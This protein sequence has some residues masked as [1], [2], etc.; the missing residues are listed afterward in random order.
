MQ[1]GDSPDSKS[2][3]AEKL[4]IIEASITDPNILKEVLDATAQQISSDQTSTSTIKSVSPKNQKDRNQCKGFGSKSTA[5]I[6][7][8]LSEIVLAIGFT[9]AMHFISQ[10]QYTTDALTTL[11][12]DVIEE[13]GGR[14]DGASDIAPKVTVPSSSSSSV[15]VIALVHTT[16]HSAQTLSRFL[17]R[18]KTSS[19]GLSSSSSYTGNPFSASVIV[20]PNDGSLSARKH[21]THTILYSRSHWHE[22]HNRI[23]MFRQ[24]Q[25]NTVSSIIPHN[26]SFFFARCLS[27]VLYFYP[28]SLTVFVSSSFFSSSSFSSSFSLCNTAEIVCEVQVTRVSSSTGKVTEASNYFTEGAGQVLLVPILKSRAKREEEEEPA[29]LHSATAVTSGTF[30]H[31]NSSATAMKGVGQDREQTRIASVGTSTSTGTGTRNNAQYD[32]RRLI[33]FDSTDPEFDEDSDPD[34]DLDL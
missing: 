30:G 27:L 18:P 8:S 26:H 25:R 22:V 5:I 4:R 1:A 12:G 7:Y 16:L 31:S 17:P 2:I 3:A 9:R 32:N 24:F 13:E 21:C 15:S 10:L 6:V 29:L 23:V 34:A 19:F 20:K 33:T 28:L 11:S 14:L